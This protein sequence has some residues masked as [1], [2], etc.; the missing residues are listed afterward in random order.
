M[1][2][3]KRNVVNPDTVVEQYGADTLRL[4]ELF[5]GPLE[6]AKPWD[7]Q[8]IEGVYRFLQKVNRHVRSSEVHSSDPDEAALRILHRCLRRVHDGLERMA[9]NTCISAMMIGMNEIQSA[10][11]FH[12]Q[13]LDPYVR[14]LAPF[15][16]HL[17]EELWA[18]LGHEP[19][20]HH[21]PY[22]NWEPIYLEQDTYLYPVQHNG[23]VRLQVE[24]PAKGLPEDL[25]RLALAHPKVVEWLNGRIP[26]KTIA[27]PGRIINMVLPNQ[28]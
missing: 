5:L 6:D 13:I 26:T 9:L 21:A 24:L 22:P 25:V 11:L 27:V 17:A 23:K 16:P 4:Y 2:K 10:G 1:Y 28:P 12:R 20:I 18:V 8:G 14:M 7:T 19:S 15:A 3:S